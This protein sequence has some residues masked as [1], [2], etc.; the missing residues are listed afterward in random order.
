MPFINFED[1]EQ[2]ADIEQLAD[3][4]GLKAKQSGRQLRCSC[5]VHGGDDRTLAITPDVRSKRGSVGVFFCQKAQSGGDRIGLVAHCMDMGQQDAAFFIAEQYGTSKGTVDSTVS[6]RTA[7]KNTVPQ[8]TEGRANVPNSKKEVEFNP[9]VFAAKL[10]FSD[11]VAALGLTE[12]DAARLGIGFTRGRVY[13]PMKDDT[14]FICGFI[15]FADGQLKMPPKW[16]EQ[17][18]VVKLKRA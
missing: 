14:G 7:P 6:A 17:S 15:G 18:K 12:Q 1:V 3:M 9:A 16:L 5:P 8:K 13:F 4:L 2:L 10:V 11:E